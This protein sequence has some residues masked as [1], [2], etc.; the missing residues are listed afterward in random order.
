MRFNRRLKTPSALLANFLWSAIFVYDIAFLGF[1]AGG[2]AILA[3]AFPAGDL[4]NAYRGDGASI[5]PSWIPSFSNRSH[6][7]RRTPCFV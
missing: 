3:N 2:Y 4:T 6:T 5:L 7:E 1:V